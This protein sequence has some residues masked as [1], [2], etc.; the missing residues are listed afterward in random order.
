MQLAICLLLIAHFLTLT[1]LKAG[2]LFVNYI[3]AAF[4]AYNLAVNAALFDG[5][6][7]FHR[8]MFSALSFRLLAFSIIYT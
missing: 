5:C 6:S 8:F 2:I 4:P 3:E 1:L 7:N